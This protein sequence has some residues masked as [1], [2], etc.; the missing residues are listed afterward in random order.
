MNNQHGLLAWERQQTRVLV[1]GDLILD[2]YLDGVVNRI[3]PEAPVPVHLVRRTT[4]TAG[5]AANVARNI[6]LVGGQAL[7]TGVCGHDSAGEQLRSILRQ[8]QIAVEH[9]VTDQDRPT[10]R[11]TRITA[12]HQQLVRVDW[13][14][15]KP[16]SSAMQ[17]NLLARIQKQDFEALL[18]SDYG[19]GGLPNSFLKTVIELG[20]SKAVPVVIDPKGKDYSGY[21]GCDLITPNRKEACEALGLDST[22]HWEPEY[23]ARELQQRYKLGAVLVTLGAEGMFGL[24]ADAEK[25]FHLDAVTREVFDVSGAGDT[26]VSIMALSLAAKLQ[27]PEAM[28]IANLAAG[29]VVEKWG[30]QPI[31]RQELLEVLSHEGASSSWQSSQRKRLPLDA[32][33]K[34]LSEHRARQQ[35]IV[36][37]NGCFDLLHAGHISY[38][39]EARSLG[40]LL[41]VGVNTDASIRRLKGPTRPIIPA[42]QR[43]S[44]LA[45]LECVDYVVDFSEDTPA[46][47]IEIVS[48]D[49]LVKGADYQ[50]HEIV[51]AD[52]VH[53]AG[54]TVKTISF[55]EGLSTSEIIAR[56][57]QDRGVEC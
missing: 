38:L 40:D 31:E 18:I 52:T 36:F 46:R 47:L 19:K 21:A 33:V 24:P 12:N 54:G 30:T 57:K 3:S 32:L 42:E 9:I 27:L 55:V 26:V 22:K 25:G 43:M 49:V 20:R 29:K 2:E 8:D 13:E 23:L 6:Q 28:R 45:A 53:R 39:E 4:V 11:K 56:V 51:G 10:V 1:V 37:T 7:I 41:V 35:K 50:I 14:E 44:L 15:T 16:I 17:E 48:P 34:H 5:G